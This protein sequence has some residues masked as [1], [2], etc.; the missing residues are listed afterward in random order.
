[1]RRAGK[2][3]SVGRALIAFALVTPKSRQIYLNETIGEAKALLWDEPDDGL[4]AVLERLGLERGEKRKDLTAGK[5]DYVAN[6]AELVLRFANGSLIYLVGADNAKQAN[7]LRGRKV[8]RVVVDEAQKLPAIDNLVKRV[9]G[10]SIKDLKGQIW[11][12]GTPGIDC[13]G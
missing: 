3:F 9:L 1:S 13:A 7:K 2:T 11:L 8:H 5:A 6:E 12:I 10:A 4:L